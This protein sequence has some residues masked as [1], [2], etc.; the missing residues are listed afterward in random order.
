MASNNGL[1]RLYAELDALKAKQYSLETDKRNLL[2]L[3]SDS[4]SLKAFVDEFEATTKPDIKNWPTDELEKWQGKFGK[5][6]NDIATKGF[7]GF[8]KTSNNINSKNLTEFSKWSYLLMNMIKARKNIEEDNAK[9]PNNVDAL[10]EKLTKQIQ[11]QKTVGGYKRK[12]TRK[13]LRKKK[14]LKRR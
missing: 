14:S 6:A 1:G 10:V 2:A 12:N 5:M 3:E 11:E 4:T 8:S 9:S 7:S 13:L